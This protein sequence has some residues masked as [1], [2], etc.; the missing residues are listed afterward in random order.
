M[1]VITDFK[2][3][4]IIQESNFNMSIIKIDIINGKNKWSKSKKKL[5]KMVL[6]IKKM[7]DSPSNKIDGF[8]DRIVEMFPGMKEH[9]CSIGKKGG[10]FKRVKEGTWMGH[11]VEHVALELQTL[12]DMDVGWGRTRGTGDLGKYNVVFNYINPNAGKYAAMAAVNLVELLINGDEY[13]LD[14]TIESLKRIKEN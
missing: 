9:R 13:N 10:F 5:I 4:N 1:K 8:Y 3:W 12:A 11:I 14:K 6:D 7:E 2:G